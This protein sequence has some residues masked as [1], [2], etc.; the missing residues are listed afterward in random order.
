MKVAVIGAGWAGLASAVELAGKVDLTVFEAGRVAGGRARSVASADF[1]FLDNGQH[2]LIGAYESVFALLAR[3]GVKHGFVREPMQWFLADGV[4]FQV[5]DKLPAPLNLL[6][7]LLGASGANG[8]DKWAL[9]RQMA[10]LRLWHMRNLPDETVENWLIQHRAS[11]KWR[12]EFW[13]PL[14][15]GALNTPLASASLRVLANVLADGV[16]HSRQSSG[17]RLPSVDLGALWVEPA[18]RYVAQHGGRYLPETRVGQLQLLDNGQISVQG[19]AFDRVIVAVAPY[20]VGALLPD[21]LADNFKKVAQTWQY[22]A[23]TTVYLRYAQ[24]V[25]LPALMTGLARGTAQWL[26]DRSR[27]N[28]SNEIAVVISVSD[29]HGRVSADE[30]VQRVHHDVAQILPELDKPVATQVITEK[31]ATFASTP[32]RILPDLS[33]LNQNGIFLA[34]D[35]LNVRYPATLESAVQSGVEMAR[36]LSCEI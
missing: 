10:C 27:I 32:N 23:I 4:R 14:V 16:W 13:Q 34:G 25:R 31:R 36:K 7:A 35:Y 20:H 3:L 21:D 5:S 18:L 24:A 26:I 11:E 6:W 22:H 28:Q 30:W 17:F 15:L 29:A 1:S 12:V 8:A 2:L 19:E 9:L 33:L